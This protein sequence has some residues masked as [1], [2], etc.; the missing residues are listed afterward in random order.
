M[1]R[2]ATVGV[3]AHV[4]FELA[5]GVGMPFAS[6]LGPVPAAALWAVGTGGV[7]RVAATRPPSSDSAL[8]FIN[9]VSLAAVI[10]HLT[11]W[12]SRRTRLGLPWL[13][14]CEGLGR[15]LMPIYN[16]IIYFSGVTALIALAVE[17]RTAPRRLP[18][19][20]GIGLVPV[21]VRAQHGEFRRLQQRARSRPGW[22][23]RRLQQER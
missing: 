23:N 8:A 3:A 9:G 15:E 10:A 2:L 13:E 6:V 7:C 11:A 19:L 21:L 16:P 4:F 17:N 20:L 22:W 12:P 1:T 14:D 5:A 18:L